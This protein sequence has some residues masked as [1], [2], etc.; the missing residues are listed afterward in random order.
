MSGDAKHPTLDQFR[1]A[2]QDR[3]VGAAKKD[4]FNKWR[5]NATKCPPGTPLKDA[6]DELWRQFEALGEAANAPTRTEAQRTSPSPRGRSSRPSRGPS[7]QRG[8]NTGAAP[9]SC[10]GEP[11]HNAYTFIPFSG[12]PPRRGS[13]RASAYSAAPGSPA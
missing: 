6:A 2:L 11:F 4:A 13:S 5:N 7:P 3:K 12:T 10:L 8:D 1:R 9:P